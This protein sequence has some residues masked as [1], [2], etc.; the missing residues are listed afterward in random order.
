MSTLVPDQTGNPAFGEEFNYDVW[1]EETTLT[2]VNVPWNNDYRDIVRFADQ[3]ALDAYIAAKPNAFIDSSSLQRFQEDVYIDIPLNRALKYNYLRAS[4]STMPVPGDIQ[5]NYYYFITGVQQVAP[6]NTRLTL[7]L[8]VWQTFGYEVHFGS[9][10]V[11]R[12]HIGIANENSFDNQGRDYLNIPEGLDVGSEY[13]IVKTAREQ[14]M[15]A[16]TAFDSADYS[17]LICS[18]VDLTKNPGNEVEP[19][20]WTA[21]GAVV[22]GIVSGA[23]F[24]VFPTVTDFRKFLTMYQG[25]PWVTQGIISVTLIP[26]VERYH[27]GATLTDVAPDIIAPMPEGLP[28]ITIVPDYVM[29]KY[30]SGL[31]Q[32]KDTALA[33]N[34]RDDL[35]ALIPSRYRHLKKFLTF[36]YSLIEITTWSGKP[37]IARPE[38]WADDDA[39]IREQAV[40]LPP[41][42]RIA[43]IPRRYNADP[44]TID[45]QSSDDDRGEYL[46]FSTAIDRFPSIPIVN[47]MAISYMASNAA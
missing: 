35:T 24:Y 7:Q 20:L 28:D 34:W 9:S 10:F 13:R 46:D 3:D 4:N 27:P 1:D 30:P 44:A 25:V 14:I 29:Y 47:N 6:S 5:R 15:G 8:D 38:S 37:L 43:I 23:S 31:S 40:M 45:L 33:P 2:M 12:G 18:T 19:Q 42:Q 16:A 32:V 22:D 41:G 26:D 21:T 36:P 39:T 11:E 17:I